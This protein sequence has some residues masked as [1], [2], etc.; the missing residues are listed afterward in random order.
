MKFVAC[1]AL[2][3]T[4]AAFSQDPAN[5]L[6][7]YDMSGGYGDAVL[8]AI[9]NLWPSCT[10]NSYTGGTAGYT[11]FNSDM[12][13]QAW[14][15][16]ICEMW[17]YNTD[18]LNWAML[19]DIHDTTIMYVSSWEWENGTSGQM[20][21]AG[22]LGVSATSPITGSVIPHYAWET[23]HPICNG[24]S[25]WG[26]NDPGL[27]TLNA[28]MTVSTATPVTGWTSSSSA[29]QAGIC[30]APNGQSIISGYT[31]AYTNEA[32][33]IWENVL[34]FMWTGGS[35]LERTTWGE[36]KSSF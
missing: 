31:I 26:W 28:R 12:A 8:T 24:I 11:S 21:L 20:T 17:Y 13:S 7:Y 27:G 29:G 19:N 3:L 30:V 16:I 1:L 22:N 36:I 14:D 6:V 4:A 33:A 15:I 34:D 23:G 18:D 9:G 2:L 5:I 35:P 25:D 10:V 32:V